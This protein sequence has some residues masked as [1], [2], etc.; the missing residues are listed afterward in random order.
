MGNYVAMKTDSLLFSRDS[1]ENSWADNFEG[2]KV[3]EDLQ[4]CVQLRINLLTILEKGLEYRFFSVEIILLYKAIPLVGN[5]KK[6]IIGK[7]CWTS[8]QIWNCKTRH[9]S[10]Y[11]ISQY[12]GIDFLKI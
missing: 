4:M 7:I 12:R 9:S 1:Q 2:L 3:H 5:Q 8:R 11:V 10:T 6:A